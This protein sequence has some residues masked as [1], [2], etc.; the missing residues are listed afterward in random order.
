V[1]I[2][3]VGNVEKVLP[4]AFAGTA[5]TEKAKEQKHLHLQ[6]VL[7]VKVILV[8]VMQLMMQLRRRWRTMESRKQANVRT[9]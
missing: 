1:A 4:S 8:V 6:V 9:V 2:F 7:V 3:Q 5:S